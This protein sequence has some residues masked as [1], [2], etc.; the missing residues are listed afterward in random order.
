MEK[1]KGCF[2]NTQEEYLGKME[3]EKIY[4]GC[5]GHNLY[6]EVLIHSASYCDCSRRW[7]LKW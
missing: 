2:E 4:W 3:N 7:Y 5:Y 1:N 6:V